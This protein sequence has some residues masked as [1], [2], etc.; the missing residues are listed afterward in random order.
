VLSDDSNGVELVL[1]GLL[2]GDLLHKR[3]EVGLVL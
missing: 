2:S 1:L 3:L